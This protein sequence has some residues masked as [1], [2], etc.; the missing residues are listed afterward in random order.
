MVTDG[1]T[2]SPTRTGLR[3]VIARYEFR[4]LRTFARVHLGAGVFLILC[5]ALTAAVGGYGWAAFFLAIAAVNLAYGFWEIRI[6]RST[7]PRS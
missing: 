4:R 6:V 2:P 5:G 3:R 1:R 7:V